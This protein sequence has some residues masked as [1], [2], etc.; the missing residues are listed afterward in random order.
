MAIHR[1]EI[2]F[3]ELGPTRGREL[4]TKRRP[5]VVLSIDDIN[6]KPLVVVV[7]PGGTRPA[8]KPIYRHE[9]KVDP[10]A[11]NGLLQSTI[12]QCIQIKALDHGR[13]D[14]GSIGEMSAEDLQRIENTVRLCL[15][16]P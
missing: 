3:V 16:L 13:F 7:V 5:V 11:T 6:T 8:G 15:G 2:Y 4:D 14:R 12:F 1:G 9:V 10:S